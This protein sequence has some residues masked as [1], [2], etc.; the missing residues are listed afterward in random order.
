[1]LNFPVDITTPSPLENSSS[2]VIVA[3]DDVL[4]A[5]R[6]MME[7]WVDP[8]YRQ[9]ATD[10]SFAAANRLRNIGAYTARAKKMLTSALL[11]VS[12]R[13]CV[14]PG[15]AEMLAKRKVYVMIDDDYITAVGYKITFTVDEDLMQAR[16]LDI[17]GRELAVLA[18]PL[19]CKD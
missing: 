19:H 7:D 13:A 12:I 17:D 16:I 6:N 2:A 14:R 1:M 4:V 18:S 11:W 8:A 10:P 5:F 3:V 9:L 15:W